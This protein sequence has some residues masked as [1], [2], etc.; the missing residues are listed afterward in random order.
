MLEEFSEGRRGC[1]FSRPLHSNT[2][3]CTRLLTVIQQA[4]AGVVNILLFQSS[5][6]DFQEEP[7]P[8]SSTTGSDSPWAK[9]ED[10]QS[11]CPL[12]EEMQMD[13]TTMYHNTGQLLLTD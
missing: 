5:A 13:C 9:R 4:F 8:A 2:E 12:T 10:L 7:P 1:L 3:R 6:L 11:L